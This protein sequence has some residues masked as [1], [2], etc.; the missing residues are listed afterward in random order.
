MWR[1]LKHDESDGE[2]GQRR[3]GPHELDNGVDDAL[4]GWAGADE[5]ANR[6]GNQ[7]PYCEANGDSLQRRVELQADALVVGP[8]VVER[9]ADELTEGR[10]R[11]DWS[12]QV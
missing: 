2:P 8:G 11:G 6:H 7:R 10:Q 12:R 1:R 3:D 4:E 9:V 5:D